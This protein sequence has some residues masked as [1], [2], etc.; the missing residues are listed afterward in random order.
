MDKALRFGA[1]PLAVVMTTTG[2]AFAEHNGVA[3][4][5][6]AERSQDL[7][8]PSASIPDEPR[9]QAPGTRDIVGEVVQVDAERGTLVVSTERGLVAFRAPASALEGVSVGDLVRVRTSLPQSAPEPL[10]PTT[11]PLPPAPPPEPT[12]ADATK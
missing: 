6:G 2:A 11:S 12:P 7:D 3:S 9:G 4:A 1:V 8:D 5:A 10:T